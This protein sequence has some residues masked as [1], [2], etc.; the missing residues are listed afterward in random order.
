MYVCDHALQRIT[1]VL[2]YITSELSVH[3]CMYV[4]MHVCMYACMHVC[5]CVTMLYYALLVC[6]HTLLF[7]TIRY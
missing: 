7:V 3:V 5:M 1:S 4:C 6:Y 2:P